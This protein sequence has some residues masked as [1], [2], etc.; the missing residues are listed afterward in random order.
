M[1]M[2]N[3]L[4]KMNMFNNDVKCMFHA[5]I[6]EYDMNAASLSLSERFQLLPK[7]TIE[8]LKLLPKD[9][10]VYRTGLIR[11]ENKEFSVTVDQKLRDVRKEFID[12]NDIKPDDILSLHSDAIIFTSRKKIKN[13]IDGITFKESSH[14][15]GYIRYNAIEMFYND[16]GMT[17]K[18]GNKELLQ[19]HTMGISRYLVKVFKYIENYDIQVLSYLSK[20]ESEYLTD[21]YPEFMYSP[22]GMPGVFKFSNLDLFAYIAKIVLKET[23][24]W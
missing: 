10:R 2:D 6:L 23:D 20:F 13:V 14:A 16:N 9:K 5:P 22:F 17:Y 3:I 4:T 1:D 12:E 11:R 7:E 15:T 19:T 21:R 8:E 18:G 24:K